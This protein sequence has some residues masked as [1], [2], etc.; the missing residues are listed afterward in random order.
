[1]PNRRDMKSAET[2]QALTSILARLRRTLGKSRGL[3]RMLQAMR[4]ILHFGPWRNGARAIIRRV[5]PPRAAM[6]RQQSLRLGLDPD[7]VVSVLRI[8]GV[9]IA[10]RLPQS[11]LEALRRVTDQLPPREYARF[12]EED[13]YIGALVRDE[14]V[15]SVV[16]KYLGCEP[17]LLECTVVVHGS[18]VDRLPPVSPQRRFH[19]DYA[20]WHSL[21]LF[22]YLTDVAETS[23]THEVVI[24]THRKKAIKDAVRPWFP[25][26]EILQRFG[27][28]VRT[29]TAPL[30]PC[31]LR[32]PR[33][34]IAADS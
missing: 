26:E 13:A 3:T 6:S 12:H 17:E 15:L 28:R 19:F 11:D 27:T 18:E 30:A 32:I 22:V 21:N 33:L 5:R 7:A 31:F 24:G 25:D 23:G 20:G 8:D 14:S 10:G 16:R 1:M 34:F 9:C 4:A 29:V 2:N